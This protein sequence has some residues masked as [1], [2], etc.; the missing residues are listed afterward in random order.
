MVEN[1]VVNVH[2][3]RHVAD[4]TKQ[5]V[6]VQRTPMVIQV[7]T[8]RAYGCFV[9]LVVILV[10]LEWLKVQ[11]AGHLQTDDAVSGALDGF[12]KG[13]VAE[14]AVGGLENVQGNL[15]TDC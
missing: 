12:L 3:F 15:F 11:R 9:S 4:V 14:L 6:A 7:E 10:C 13:D 5:V 1:H 2:S 8:S